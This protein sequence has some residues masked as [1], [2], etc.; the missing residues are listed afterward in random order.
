V[1]LRAVI[2]D[3]DGVVVDSEPYSMQ[4]LVDVLGEYGIVPSPD[5][6]RRSYGRTLTE[7]FQ[8][9]FGHHG[10]A[11]DVRTA[12]ARKRARYFESAA[13]KL[14]PFPG[15][16]S[17]LERVAARG[18]RLAAA[19]SGERDKVT[20]TLD[21]LGLEGRFEVIV[22]GDDVRHSKPDPAIYLTAA[23]RLGVA[24]EGCLA[25][26]DAPNG[27]LAA[28]RAG[29]RC[30][31]ITNSVSREALAGADAIVESLTDDLSAIL[32]L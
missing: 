2:F 16:L 31:A 4:A 13:G 25:I 32:P 21:A 18:Y 24:P 7:D 6:L 10:V 11:A 3:L 30:L 22:T 29:M 28:K 1:D 14:R 19:S 5:E 8:D 27:V 15:V 9:Y 26:E 23:A 17:L 12:V 20:F